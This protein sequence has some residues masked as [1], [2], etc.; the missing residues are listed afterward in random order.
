MIF[1]LGDAAPTRPIAPRPQQ[2]DRARRL[3]LTTGPEDDRKDSPLTRV[4]RGFQELGWTASDN[5]RIDDCWAV[6]SNHRRQ[7]GGTDH[8]S[9]GVM[10]ASTSPSMAERPLT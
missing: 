9:A 4:L 2:G 5:L 8:S 3:P 1:P 6:D 7:V 10:M